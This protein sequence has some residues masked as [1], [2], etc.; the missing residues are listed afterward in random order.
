MVDWGTLYVRT[1]YVLTFGGAAAAFVYAVYNGEDFGTA[2]SEAFLGG[3]VG[4]TLSL[5]LPAWIFFALLYAVYY[6]LRLI[7]VS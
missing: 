2:F 7:L 1:F 3:L 5:G 6:V 4:A